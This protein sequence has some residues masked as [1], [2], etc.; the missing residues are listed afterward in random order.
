[1][2]GSRPSVLVSILSWESPVYLAKLLA[3]LDAVP[4]S[5]DGRTSAH[6]HVLDQGG[7][8][9]TREAILRF[10]T[11]G[12][13]RSVGF[14][15]RNVGFPVGHNHVFEKVYR[16]RRFDYFVPLNQD[17]VFERP[18]WLDRLVEGMADESIAVAGPTAWQE[19][20]RPGI[21]L[22]PCPAPDRHP[23]RIFSIQ[24]SVAIIRTAMIERFGLFDSVF[25]PAYFEDTDLCRRYVSAGY[26]LAWIGVEH[27]HAY[28]DGV[29]KLIWR[30]AEELKAGFGDFHERNR[31]LFLRRWMTGRVPPITADMV[32]R[33]WPG[34]YRP[35]A[36]EPQ[37]R[38][39][40]R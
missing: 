1:M 17:V 25:T 39:D 20:Q 15:K 9:D 5:L 16:K 38:S 10:A 35:T 34:V 21:A 14:L 33:L 19:S 23:D 22:E 7:S 27:K 18:G 32:P 6:I 4:P 3:N 11:S 26:R 36:M 29:D 28:L 24:A 31:L 2:T 30:K 8:P 12:S 40:A 37:A 13:N